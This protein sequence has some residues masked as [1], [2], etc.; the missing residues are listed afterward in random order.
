MSKLLLF[1]M[2]SSRLLLASV[3]VPDDYL[4]WDDEALSYTYSNEHATLIPAMKQYQEE[5]MQGYE[6][7]YGFKLDDKL[8]VGLASS[9]NQIANGFSTQI[10]FNM[11]LFY[12][13]GAAYIDYFSA[14]SWLKTLI[15]HETAHNFQLNPK[16]NFLS[17]TSH[18]ILGN[19][20]VSF[21]GFLPLFPIPNILESNFVLEG[22]A[23]MNES[24]FDNGGRLFSGYALA[25]VVTLARAGKITPELMFNNTLEFPY[26]EQWYLVGGFFHQFLVEQYGVEK[27]NGYFKTFASQAFPF[28]H[29]SMFKEHYGKSFISLLAEFVEE[30]TLNHKD[31]QATEGELLRRSQIF[32]PLNKTA[33]EIYT[34]VGDNKS[35]PKV[36]K[37]NTNTLQ[38]RLLKGSWRVGE[39][40]KRNGHYY[41]QASAKTSPVTIEMGLFDK[42]GFM[43][44][45]F[46]G[47]AVQ[48]FTT[49]GRAVYFDV[50]KSIES[51]QVYV[52]GQF[53]TQA[54][55]SVY[56]D[57][58]D[59]YY[60]KQKGSTRTLYKNKS[61]LTSFEGHY[62]FVTDVDATGA[63]YFIAS[64]KHGSTAYKVENGSIKR[65][66]LADDVIDL[67]LINNQE[68]M[69][70]TIDAEGYGYYKIRLASVA[71]LSQRI[72]LPQQN[73]F[74]PEN[75]KE[76]LFS[77]QQ[78]PLEAEAYH[79]LTALKFS[80][81]NQQFLYGEE[82]GI[83][84]N[85]QANFS[86]Q[87]LQNSLAFVLS[88]DEN[89]EIA[90]LAYG[91]NAHYLQYGGALYG[92]YKQNEA[93]T[94]DMRELGY[95]AYLKLPFLAT[96]YWRGDTTLAYTQDYDNI[97][98]KPLTLSLN[99]RNSRQ[100]GLSKY[101][102]SLNALS[103]FGTL[104]RERKIWGGAYQFKQ[105]LAW[106][107]Y[108]G[109]E[110]T[111][112]KSDGVNFFEEQGIELRE[113]LSSL[114]SDKAT[115]TVPSFSSTT[116]AQEVKM[117][118][119]SL[120]K[121]FDG[122]LYLFSLP[123]S[124]QRESLYAKQR[125]YQIDFSNSIE[126]TYHET[127]VGL[128]LDLLLFHKLEMPLSLEWIHNKDVVDQNK[129]RVL[130]GGSF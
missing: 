119:L 11:Q 73:G 42:N 10:P 82:S 6:A 33:E 79:E 93:T 8:F 103:L 14:T 99:V 7:E 123:L 117:A 85:L 36:F 98:R 97:Y 37:L 115:L 101:A 62:G 107:S 104:D 96:G 47:K 31:F 111:Y 4:V 84:F 50:A 18:T 59:F 51:P 110:A 121:V 34:L 15:I 64:S 60:F 112:M 116:Y 70:T 38:Q 120:A 13:A 23:V 102:N 35:L 89:R 92:V 22:N 20:P 44:K 46:E 109:V 26:G 95:D 27:V 76:Q 94:Q 28:F 77:N 118:E 9:H 53:Y 30:I 126:R 105:D 56:V 127:L 21:L 81:L 66:S 74:L 114:Q 128:E 108:L 16:E 48:G 90:G 125:L 80:A 71:G 1:L 41:S 129:V 69:V 113:G 43:Q 39:L 78:K 55:S 58:E 124:L 91:N 65:V 61:A 130:F 29:N 87:L 2:L 86:D 17:K 106:Q 54:H 3:V 57:N 68:A 45:G 63:V 49:S 25:E 75:L 40:F 67:K 88:H 5:I 83:E 12:G 32:V 122:S 24:R 19:S 72:D 100:F 52:D